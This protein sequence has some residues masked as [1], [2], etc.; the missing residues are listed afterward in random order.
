MKN[1]IIITITALYFMSCNK[2]NEIPD[3]DLSNSNA[4]KV[5]TYYKEPQNAG[6]IHNEALDYI[7]NKLSTSYDQV[8]YTEEM[9]VDSILKYNKEFYSIKYELTYSQ[10]EEFYLNYNFITPELVLDSNKT[11]SDWI[12]EGYNSIQLNYPVSNRVYLNELMALLD[13]STN[14][15]LFLAQ[16]ELIINSAISTLGESGAKK[17]IAVV[18]VSQRSLQ[19]WLQNSGK[20]DLIS[21]ENMKAEYNPWE[22]LT[23]DAIGGLT[24]AGDVWFT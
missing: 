9:W 16:T 21:P 17:I 18:R 22:I 5:S 4:L 24:A 11:K 7:Y 2:M 23:A 13:T 20:W 12:A 3:V 14:T 10:I 15:A 1:L 8:G 6:L 19:Y